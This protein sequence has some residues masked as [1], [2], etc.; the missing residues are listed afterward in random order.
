MEGFLD[1][2]V[3]ESSYSTFERAFEPIG[4]E[5]HLKDEY[6]KQRIKIYDFE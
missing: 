5:K 6:F 4:K 2:L 3:N 1:D